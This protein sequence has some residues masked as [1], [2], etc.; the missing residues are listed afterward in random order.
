MLV[1][2]QARFMLNSFKYQKLLIDA[3]YQKKKDLIILYKCQKA[4]KDEK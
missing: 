2:K 1:Q 3:S 4:Q